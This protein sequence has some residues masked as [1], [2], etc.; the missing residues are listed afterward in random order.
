[1]LQDDLDIRKSLLDLHPRKALGPH[2]FH[3]ILY[4]HFLEVTGPNVCNYAQCVWKGD[5]DLTEINLTNLVVVLKVKDPKKIT[6]F[7]R[8]A[9]CNTIYKILLKMMANKLKVVLP[10]VIFELFIHG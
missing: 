3:S 6:Q 5:N 2:S 4:Q 8:I 7:R 9:L 10:K 1:M